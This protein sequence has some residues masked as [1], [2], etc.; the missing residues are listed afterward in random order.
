[1]K[2][3]WIVAAVACVALMVSCGGEKKKD[4]P[5]N[6]TEQVA[7][8][9]ASEIEAQARVYRA[10]GEAILRSGDQDEAQ[11]F[12]VEVEAWVNS[13][14]KKHQAKAKRILGM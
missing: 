8:D 9:D 5:A 7:K 13:L 2:K 1:M 3:M 10:E 4:A 12:I 6:G 11:A 14:P